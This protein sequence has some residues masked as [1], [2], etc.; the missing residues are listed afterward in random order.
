MTFIVV[1]NTRIEYQVEIFNTYHLKWYSKANG[2][3]LVLNVDFMTLTILK[4]EFFSYSLNFIMYLRA[5]SQNF[6][7]N[8]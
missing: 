3:V 6:L 4:L 7:E 8:H 1:L 2:W 5:T